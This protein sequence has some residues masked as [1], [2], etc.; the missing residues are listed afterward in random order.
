MEQL[1]DLTARQE[2]FVSEYC[3]LGNGSEAARRA[4]YSHRTAREMASENLTKPAIQAAILARRA[5]YRT[6]IEITKSDVVGGILAAINIARERGDASAMIRGCVELARLLGFYDQ[7]A[8]KQVM[9]ASGAAMFARLADLPDNALMAIA[10]GCSPT[11]GQ[12]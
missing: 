1:P 3:A 8:E 7:P 2:R 12:Q 11:G 10:A 4:G 5:E 9:S 6:V